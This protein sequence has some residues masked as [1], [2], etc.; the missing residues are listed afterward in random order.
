MREGTR[1]RGHLTLWKKILIGI[2]A[3]KYFIA[4][5]KLLKKIAP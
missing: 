2:L 3:L 1:R 5:K 4:P